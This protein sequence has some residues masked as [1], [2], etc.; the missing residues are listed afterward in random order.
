MLLKIVIFN[1]PDRIAGEIYTWKNDCW[2]HSGVASIG[3]VVNSFDLIETL[4]RLVKPYEQ[5]D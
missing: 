1:S 4:L 2:E 3:T 5:Y